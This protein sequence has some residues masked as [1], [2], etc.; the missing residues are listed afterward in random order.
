MQR[1]EDRSCVFHTIFLAEA[2]Y[3]LQYLSDQ[4]NIRI[5]LCLVV[6]E[7]DPYFMDLMFYGKIT[8]F[9][10]KDSTLIFVIEK[11]AEKIIIPVPMES[12]S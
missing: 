3:E 9:I 8:K 12:Y 5:I 4:C 10:K 2:S 6:V 11:M 1:G 7:K